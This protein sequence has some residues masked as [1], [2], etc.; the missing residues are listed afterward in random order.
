VPP[1]SPPSKNSRRL[2]IGDLHGCL[3]ELEQLLHVFG[4]RPGHDQA[5]SLG[6]VVGKGPDAPGCLRLLREIRAEVVCGNHD[7]FLLTGA[8]LPETERSPQHQAYLE[9]LGPGLESHLAFMRTWPYWLEQHDIV[10]VHAGLVPGFDHPRDMPSRLLLRIRTWDGEGKHLWR[11]G[12][13][14]WFEC[15]AWPKTVVFGHW[16][17]RGLVDLPGF[18]GLDTGCVYGRQLTGYCPEEDRIVQV[19]ARRAYQTIAD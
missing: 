6:D 17:A 10:A 4:F 3:A 18:K 16:A 15:Q 1:S 12:D 5:I 11:Q 7:A 14:A 13:P 9:S 2:F 19:T 8:A